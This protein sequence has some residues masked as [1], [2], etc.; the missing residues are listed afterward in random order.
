MAH[1]IPMYRHD[2]GDRP[3]FHGGPGWSHPGAAY[4]CYLQHPG[5]PGWV[6]QEAL[7]AEFPDPDE[8]YV[9]KHRKPEQAGYQLTSPPYLTADREPPKIA[10]RSTL[11][12]V[13]V[14][15]DGTI[16]EPLWTPEN[17]TSEIGVPI[18]SNLGKLVELTE[19][20]YKIVI[21]TSRPWTDYEA[22]ETWLN[23]YQ[24][25]WHQ[26]QCGKPLFALYVDDRGRHS[27]EESWLP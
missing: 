15:L 1:D 10:P 11:L 3:Y 25:P 23:H 8:V 7:E 9:P 26:I 19:A 5:D 16:A 12:W 6:D 14:D 2:G 20:G 24:I 27:E 4:E 18:W 17:P 13:G 21:H 22:I